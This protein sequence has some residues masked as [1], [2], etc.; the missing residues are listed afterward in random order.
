MILAIILGEA[1]SVLELIEEI[2]EQKVLVKMDLDVA[3]KLVENA[4][5]MFF[6]ECLVLVRL[7]FVIKVS[8]YVSLKL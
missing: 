6:V 5:V 2:R 7:P 1:E 3:W 8:L 4:E